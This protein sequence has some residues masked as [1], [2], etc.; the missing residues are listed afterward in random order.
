MCSS[1]RNRVL[2][3]RVV[4]AILCLFC[5]PLGAAALGGPT[6]KDDVLRRIQERA[7]RMKTLVDVRLEIDRRKRIDVEPE[8]FDK[9]VD[10]RRK[11][12]EEDLRRL[13]HFGS[14]LPQLADRTREEFE[15]LVDR[16]ESYEVRFCTD[17]SRW[18]LE[19][20]ALTPSKYFAA[21]WM[22]NVYAPTIQTAGPGGKT[23]T[24]HGYAVDQADRSSIFDGKTGWHLGRVTDEM[25][26]IIDANMESPATLIEHAA[27]IDNEGRLVDYEKFY[28]QWFEPRFYAWPVNQVALDVRDTEGQSDIVVLVARVGSMDVEYYVDASKGY[29]VTKAVAKEGDEVRLSWQ[30]TEWE[31]NEGIWY[32]KVVEVQ[33]KEKSELWRVPGAR[34]VSPPKEADVTMRIEVVSVDFQPELDER[35]FTPKFPA[36]TRFKDYRLL[37]SDGGLPTFS[38][39]EPLEGAGAVMALAAKSLAGEAADV[40]LLVDLDEALEPPEEAAQVSAEQ[41]PAGEGAG[42]AERETGER[43]AP[44]RVAVYIVLAGAGCAL[45]AV[46]VVLTVRRGRRRS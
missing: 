41:P 8:V 14:F 12:R 17:G 33:A 29:A 18:R 11:L 5:I 38:S 40:S 27:R 36:N 31:E 22:S 46:V 4:T 19:E 32:P 24:H 7:E 34:E 20:R 2:K 9:I 35:E 30:A 21:E 37:E 45:L 10:L 42:V 25:R 6:D 15:V 1:W 44:R 39:T 43:E 3:E 23:V 26:N 13:S 16:Q 28:Q